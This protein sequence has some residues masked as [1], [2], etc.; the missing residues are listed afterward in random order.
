MPS[1]F[2]SL[3]SRVKR[4][5]RGSRPVEELPTH[6]P[7]RPG[8]SV[9]GPP[10]SQLSSESYLVSD[11][12]RLRLFR[13]M[14]GIAAPHQLGFEKRKL[15]PG[16]TYPT[17]NTGAARIIED[18]V[19]GKRPA[20]NIGLYGRVVKA[21]QRAQ[22]L[23]RVLSML[24]NACY[25]LQI[26][27]GASLTAMGAAGADNRAIT[28]FGAINT[29][30]A[31][32][33]TYLKGSGIPERYKYFADEWK[34]IREAIEQW[35][36]EFSCLNCAQDVHEVVAT[37]RGMYHDT[38][39]EIEMNTPDSYSSVKS[40]RTASGGRGAPEKTSIISMTGHREQKPHVGPEA[41]PAKDYTRGDARDRSREGGVP[42]ITVAEF[43]EPS[44]GPGAHRRPSQ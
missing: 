42:Q 19:D 35:E 30:I 37:I 5:P 2:N 26:I 14:L 27:I 33:L 22:M 16:E 24:I 11:D 25:F 44:H 28:A 43:A 36:R 8:S 10:G 32:F 20:N 6:Q 9:L 17:D 23:Y 39:R 13:L 12:N 1:L 21:E 7:S 4:H 40:P 41:S 31:G 15:H 34:K 3:I 38:V 18:N 29:I